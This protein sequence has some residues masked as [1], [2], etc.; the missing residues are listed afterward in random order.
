MWKSVL[1]LPWASKCYFSKSLGAS[2]RIFGCGQFFWANVPVC[3]LWAQTENKNLKFLPNRTFFDG[4]SHVINLWIFGQYLINNCIVLSWE[5][6]LLHWCFKALQSLP[7]W[8][9]WPMIE[10]WLAK[11]VKISHFLGVYL[12]TYILLLSFPV[13]FA[14][15]K[16]QI[17]CYS[18][19]KIIL[20]N[21][22]AFK[23]I[24]LT[25]YFYLAQRLHF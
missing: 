9:G 23:Q 19:L 21:L 8:P 16:R 1:F 15:V 4:L 13:F 6:P 7:Y 22:S 17:W 5:L 12:T 10:A 25:E 24:F 18:L 14:P 20:P 2:D 3:W 11:N